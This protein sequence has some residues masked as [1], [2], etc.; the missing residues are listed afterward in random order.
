MFRITMYVLWGNPTFEGYLLLEPPVL[1][2]FLSLK[3]HTIVKNENQTEQKSLIK[4]W[5][6]QPQNSL[7]PYTMAVGTWSDLLPYVY[8]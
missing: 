3:Q 7:Q 2:N 4:N 8:F 1:S 6:R 5:V